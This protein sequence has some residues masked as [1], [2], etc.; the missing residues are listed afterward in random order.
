MKKTILTIIAVLLSMVMVACS[1]PVSAGMVKSDKPRDTSPSG[2]GLSELVE[3]NSE[4]A[5]ALYQQLKEQNDGNIFYSPYSLSLALAMAYV[6]AEGETADQIADALHFTLSDDA[7]HEAF[8]YLALELEKRGENLHATSDDDKGFQLNVVNDAWG[9][10][11]FEFLA[12]YLDTLAVNYGAGLRILDFVNDAEAARQTINQ[13]ISDQTNG[14]IE[15]LIP[16]GAISELTRLVLTNA[17]Y[18]N[19]SWQVPFNEEATGNG[20]FTLLDGSQVEVDMMHQMHSFNYVQGEGYQAIELPYENGQLSMLILLPDE[21]RFASFEDALDSALVGE[22][23][24]G[25]YSQNLILSLPK[26]QFDSSFGLNQALSSLGMQQAFTDSAD[27]SGITGNRDL[28]ISDVIH[29]AY[30]SV[31]E[32][33]TEAAAASAVIMVASGMPS[34]PITLSV[35]RPFIFLIRDIPTGSIL[36]VGRVVNPAA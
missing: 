11:N 1:T 25:L 9:Q 28:F 34:E 15:D 4:F 10:E 17:I 7:L 5:F 29:K 22:V 18:F 19:A 6:G 27:F 3:G 30:V 16:E 8:N 14:K 26:F 21:G 24:A 36:F 33:G 13:Y 35:N 31:N 2:S 12:R 20:T 23:I 32:A